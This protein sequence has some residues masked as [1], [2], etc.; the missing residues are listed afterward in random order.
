MAGLPE[1]VLIV[2]DQDLL[3]PNAEPAAKG[4]MVI[5]PAIVDRDGD[6]LNTGTGT[7]KPAK[8]LS[9]NFVPVPYP[10]YHPATI[11]MRPSERQLWRVLNSSA[12]T[13]LNL[14]VLLNGGPQ[15]LGVVALDG[16]PINHN[17]MRRMASYG[18]TTWEC[19]LAAESNLL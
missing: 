18:R 9:L 16:V 10:D 5:P 19:R 3:N 14:Q 2:R 15:M 8:D 1:R 11:M 12:I 6:A 13:Y 7:G 4:G 17:G